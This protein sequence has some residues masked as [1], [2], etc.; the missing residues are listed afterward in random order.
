MEISTLEM[1][2]KDVVREIRS[3]FGLDVAPFEN[4]D[5]DLILLAFTPRC[6]RNAARLLEKFGTCSNETLEFYGDRVLYDVV[7]Y[8]VYTF[9]RLDNTPGFLSQLVSHLTT[10]RILTDLMLDKKACRYLRGPPYYISRMRHFHNPCADAFEALVG[11]LFVFL[12]GQGANYV[13]IIAGWLTK[14]TGFLYFF[15]EYLVRLAGEGTAIYTPLDTEMIR[16]SGGYATH[17]LLVGTDTGLA[18]IYEMLGWAFRLPEYDPSKGLFYMVGY[19]GGKDMVI[20]WGNNELEAIENARLF[21]TNTGYIV[22]LQPVARYFRL[23]P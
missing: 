14:N 20:G 7:S 10:N 3:V 12:S 1:G 18:V 6:D 2:D 22:N 4:M 15:R 13:P 23:L 9:F 16:R 21:L 5:D 17:S 11:A 19:P 8:I